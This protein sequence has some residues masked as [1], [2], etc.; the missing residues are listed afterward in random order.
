MFFYNC[1]A[2]NSSNMSRFQ[3]LLSGELRLKLVSGMALKD[4]THR[5]ISSNDVFTDGKQ[6]KDTLWCIVALQFLR[7]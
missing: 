6:E 4:K 3:A 1:L 2:L 5:S 7:V